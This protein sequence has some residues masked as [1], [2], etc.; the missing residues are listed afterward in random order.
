MSAAVIHLLTETDSFSDLHGAALQRWVA[1][2]LRWETERTTVACAR[3]DDSW[4]LKHAEAL[5][6]PGLLAYSKLRGRY[7]LPW[8]LRRSMLRRIF[9]PVT[10]ALRPGSVIWI[11]NRP[12]YAAAVE[13]E[14]RAAGARLVLHLHN[15][16]A[17]SFPRMIPAPINADRIVFC[18]RYLEDEARL[19]FPGLDETAVIHN[20]ADDRRFFPERLPGS[21]V[22]RRVPRVLFAG[23]LVPEKGAHVFVEAMWLL[24]AR[25]IRV[26]GRLLGATGFGSTN[27]PTA[28]SRS[29][30]R[31]A[32]ANL[33]FGGYRP[34]DALAEEFRRADIFCSPSTWEEPFGLVNVEAM[35]SGLPVVSTLGG[36]VPE[37]F[38]EGGAILVPRDSAVALASALE[39]L[40]TDRDLRERLAVE[41]HGSYLRNFTWQRV[42]QRYREVLT[43]LAAEK[44]ASP[45][46]DR[47]RDNLK[48]EKEQL[49][50]PFP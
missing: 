12:D 6:L 36:G 43:G 27:P 4:D 23:R 42:H 11:H 49:C 5:V 26:T 32:P 39:R 35:A 41:G 34:A 31:N 48:T 19:A 47:A 8:K 50:Q 25:G 20:G 9:R 45:L 24:Q 33:E 17:V 14:V 18:S 10:K 46:H 3:A 7:R 15:S 16:L 22:Q 40:I 2:V 37:V 30:L 13:S 44:C 21:P 29:L 38:A 28:Y 1:N